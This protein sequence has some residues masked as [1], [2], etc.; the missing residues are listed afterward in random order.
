MCVCVCVCVSEVF[1]SNDARR[2]CSRGEIGSTMG[3]YP[4]GTGLNPVEGNPWALF[5]FMAAL[6]FVF[7]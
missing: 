3:E 4:G 7:L 2:A 5:S 6:S 1:V